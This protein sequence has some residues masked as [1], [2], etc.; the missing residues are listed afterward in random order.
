MRFPVTIPGGSGLTTFN[1]ITVD[2]HHVMSDAGSDSSWDGNARISD[3]MMWNKN[4]TSGSIADEFVED[5]YNNGVFEPSVPSGSLLGWR[6]RF[7]DDSSDVNTRTVHA[8]YGSG[9]NLSGSYT[10][11]FANS[12]FAVTK[13]ASQYFTDLKTAIESHN[14]DGTYFNVNYDEYNTTASSTLTSYVSG[15]YE[16]AFYRS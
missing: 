9:S 12:C 7:G 2:Q 3:F 4:L 8:T 14:S 11:D 15:T 1:S 6:Y 5:I 16:L 13:S 10:E